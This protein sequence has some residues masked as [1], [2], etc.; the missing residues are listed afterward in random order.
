MT[1]QNTE[2]VIQMLMLMLDEARVITEPGSSLSKETCE[3]I[4]QYCFN[5]MSQAEFELSLRNKN[6]KQSKF[7]FMQTNGGR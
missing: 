3:F 4:L 1:L 7:D 6:N 5:C 2:E